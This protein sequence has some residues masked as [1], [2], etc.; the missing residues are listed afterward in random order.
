[1]YDYTPN[2]LKCPTGQGYKRYSLLFVR[3]LM[4]PAL[5]M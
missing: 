5:L 3:H 4:V 2:A 1:M